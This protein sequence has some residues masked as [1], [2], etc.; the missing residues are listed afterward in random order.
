[1]ITLQELGDLVGMSAPPV[2]LKAV[3]RVFGISAP[4]SLR[5][6]AETTQ[7]GNVLRPFYIVGHNPNTIPEV[8]AA[9]DAGAN[10]IEP[11]VN[12]YADNESELCISHSEG[13][14]DA[15]SLAQFLSSLHDVA[16]Q[17]PSLAL[18]VFDCKE[19]VATAQH[20]T[21]LLKAI[22]TLLTPGT[23]LNVIISV[24]SLPQPRIFDNIKN[25]LE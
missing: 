22:R 12:V 5:Q 3:A 1:M 18:V 24:S 19:K 14:P 9:L 20:G 11:D 13:K 2:S 21:T 15:P 8:I 16:I 6:L 23:G 7:S 10:A 25:S 4:F 17:R